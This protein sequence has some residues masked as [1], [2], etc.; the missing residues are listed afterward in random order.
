MRPPLPQ[1][2]SKSLTSRF[3]H[4]EDV[5]TLLMIAGMMVAVAVVTQRKL[6]H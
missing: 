2:G 1:R 5:M 4:Q 3:H 6:H